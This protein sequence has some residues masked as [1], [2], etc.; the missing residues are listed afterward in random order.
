[1]IK[2]EQI[3]TIPLEDAALRS[4][5]LPELVHLNDPA[6]TVMNDFSTMPPLTIDPNDTMDSALN[7]MKLKGVHLLLVVDKNKKIHGIISSEDLMGEKPITLIQQRRVERNQ[8]FVKM[9]M[10]PLE[11]IVAFDISDIETARVGN[12]V[13]T[14]KQLRTHY[15][16]AVQKDDDENKTIRGLFNTS[17]ISK[18][19][20]MDI[21]N[22]IAKAQSVS[23]LQKRHT[24]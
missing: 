21:A 14:M 24:K 15:A 4:H 1:M 22:E 13:E 23:E 3:P 17:Q 12:I 7:E 11:Q 19:L 9:I 20:H 5:H 2:Y 8:I 16:M 6:F 10:V 18:Q